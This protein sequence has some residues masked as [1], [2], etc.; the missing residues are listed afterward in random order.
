MTGFPNA[1]NLIIKCTRDILG[2]G[3]SFPLHL[4]TQASRIKHRIRYEGLPYALLLSKAVMRAALDQSEIR[5]MRKSITLSVLL[6]A[7]AAQAQFI[8]LR[9]H[10][11]DVVNG[12]TVTYT[13]NAD[14]IIMEVHLET[15]LNGGDDRIVN[16]KRYER[17][18]QAG[19]MNYFCWGVCYDAQEAG[20]RPVW[21]SLPVHALEMTPGE[22]LT[23]FGGYHMPMGLEGTNTYRYVWFDVANPNDS[24]W[25]DIVFQSN[26]VGISEAAGAVRS[27]NVFPNPSLGQNVEFQIELANGVNGAVLAV[28]D[29]LGARVSNT[30][31]SAMSSRTVLPV[32]DMAPGVYFASVERN[33]S[34]LVTKRFVVTR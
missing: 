5:N 32:A 31:L 7:A 30:R 34:A 2:H 19:T 12:G 14:E 23:N 18:V 26:A 17:G 11:G 33:G 28:Y 9:D 6:L 27:M 25:A 4:E 22:P 21:A 13:G 15:T 16:V 3:L 1:G 29:M 24:V 20:A 8:T 10:H